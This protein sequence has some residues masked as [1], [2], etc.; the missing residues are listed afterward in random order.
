M[1]GFYLNGKLNLNYTWT[2]DWGKILVCIAIFFWSVL[3][4]GIECNKISE[5]V[6]LIKQIRI[7]KN[8]ALFEYLRNYLIEYR[9]SEKP[10]KDVFKNALLIR[11]VHLNTIKPM[12][13]VTIEL[14]KNFNEE[15]KNRMIELNMLIDHWI[16]EFIKDGNNMGVS[17]DE[18]FNTFAFLLTNVC[19]ENI[20]K[21]KVEKI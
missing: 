2:D 6:K 9:D 12:S 14:C 7:D 4:A 19:L 18:Q 11:L 20:D 3:N 16:E 1:A 5:Y 13:I 17:D 21:E 15:D 8:R 10:R